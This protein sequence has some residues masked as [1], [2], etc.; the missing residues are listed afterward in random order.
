ME[1]SEKMLMELADEMGVGSQN[2]NDMNRARQAAGSMRGKSE[3]EI[4]KEI[5]TLKDQIKKD[6]AAYQK[7]LRAIRALKGMMD[8]QQRAR[9][10]RVLELLER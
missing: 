1:I 7:Q 6:P 8:P 4:L 3:E 5:L 2:G 10:D 9:L